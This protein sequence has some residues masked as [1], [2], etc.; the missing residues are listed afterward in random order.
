MATRSVGSTFLAILAACLLAQHGLAA[1]SL[2]EVCLKICYVENYSV[3]L[4]KQHSVPRGGIGDLQD[5]LTVPPCAPEFKQ[6]AL[7]GATSD[8]VRA[9]QR[10]LVLLTNP[11][12]EI[13][14][15]FGPITDAAVKAF[16]SS[17]NLQ[18]L[19]HRP[20]CKTPGD[21]FFCICRHL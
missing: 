2:F 13:D 12:L 9:L 11:A 5:L 14:G 8:C 16:Q 19:N 6:G 3:L 1:V 17:N 18:V 15:D 21:W 10:G 7:N 20:V 4:L